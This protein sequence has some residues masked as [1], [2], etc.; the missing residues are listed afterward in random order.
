VVRAIHVEDG[1]TVKAG[2]VLIELDPTI[3]DAARQHAR[4]DLI[5]ARLDVAR[6]RA[7]LSD[8]TDPVADFH[9]PPQ[10][11]PAQIDTQRQFLI[12]QNGEERAKLAAFDHQIAQ[13]QAERATSQATINKIEALVPLLQQQVDIREILSEH[14]TGSRLVYL[15]TLQTLVEQQQELLVQKNHY[16][17]TDAGAAAIISAR[18]QAVEEY[19]RTHLDD[20]VKAEAKA[21]DLTQDLVKAEERTQLQRLTSPIGG[22]VQ[23]L[24]VYTVG[25]VVTPAQPLL[26]VVPSDTDLEIRALVPNRDVGFVHAGQTVDIKID[27]FP[28]TRYGLLHGEVESISA[29]AITAD[30]RQDKANLRSDTSSR[31]TND[32]SARNQSMRR[33]YRSVA[34]G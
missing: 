24:A 29:D 22:V 6:L 33:A 23:Q 26:V 16:R 11:S 5:A 19:R 12:T 4:S 14:K 28:Y 8:G 1:Q 13:K 27:T 3:N 18:V 21:A 9:P 2:D 15:E 20:L 10:A 32:T 34:H 7:A 31:D 17:E 30:E 25:G